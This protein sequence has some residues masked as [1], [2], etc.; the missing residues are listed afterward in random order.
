M[1]ERNQQFDSRQEWINKGKSWLT[2]HPQWG[3]HFKAICFDAKGRHVNCGGDFRRAEEEGAFP[4]RWLW[5]DQ[6]AAMAALNVELLDALRG[7]PECAEISPLSW[8]FSMI[9]YCKQ[10]TAADEND[11][12][13]LATAEMIREVEELYRKGK[14]AVAKT[15]A[16]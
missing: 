5:P 9:E 12:D 16:V 1:S 14:A 15:E 13:P 8:L 6:I 7:E 4:V 11:E 10:R 3:E 2:R